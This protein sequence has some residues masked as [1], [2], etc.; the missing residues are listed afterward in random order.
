MLAHVRGQHH[1]YHHLPHRHPLLVGQTREDVTGRVLEQLEGDR[2]V[3]V[4]QNSIIIVHQ[5]KVSTF[6]IIFKAYCE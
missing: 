2:Q 1:V 4:L 3:V 6:N 5:S